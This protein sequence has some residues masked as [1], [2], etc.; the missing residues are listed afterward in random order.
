[1]FGALPM[2]YHFGVPAYNRRWSFG[3]HDICFKNRCASH[4]GIAG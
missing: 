3:S 1:L 4:F 2:K